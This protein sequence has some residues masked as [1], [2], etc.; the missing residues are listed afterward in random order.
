MR[1]IDLSERTDSQ[2]KLNPFSGQ[3]RNAINRIWRDIG[4]D[5]GQRTQAE[6]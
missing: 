4:D 3:M 5:V 1:A 6:L 2:K